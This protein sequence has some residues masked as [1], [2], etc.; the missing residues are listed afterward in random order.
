MNALH[1]LLLYDMV[2]KYLVYL[3]IVSFCRSCF[4]AAFLYACFL[5]LSTVLIVY[6]RRKKTV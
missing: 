3:L 4:G 5:V 2:V 6:H 1:F